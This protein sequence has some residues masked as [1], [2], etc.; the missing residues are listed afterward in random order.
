MGRERTGRGQAHARSAQSGDKSQNGMEEWGR[1]LRRLRE[2]RGWSQ[3]EL[4]RRMFCDDST[5]SRLETG[6]LAP[7]EKTAQA[8]D[9][10]LELRGSLVSLREIL[11]G[12]GSGQWQPDVAE[13]EKRATLLQHWE[14]CYV[15]GLVQTEPYM[16]EVFL[17]GRP[18]ATDEQIS[19]YVAERL[20]RQEIWQRASPPPPMLHAVI[21]EPALWVPVGGVDVMRTQLKELAEAA[22]SNRRVRLQVLPLK[23]G[24]HSGMGGAFL[25]ANFADERPAAV[26]DDVLTGHMTERRS[27]VARLA[28]LF[29]TLSADAL[30]P[31]A[32]VDLIEKVA[33]ESG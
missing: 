32:S 12:L 10:A 3:A 25:V 7:T 1:E 6:D 31:Q 22:R 21:W 4:A 2:D 5:I 23:H 19:Q 13:M 27:E 26:L 18:D 17:T 8:A 33:D 16:R 9:E 24:A 11:M 20:E 14:P 15:P 29:S 30:S 28:L